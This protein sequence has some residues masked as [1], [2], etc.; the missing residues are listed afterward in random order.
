[1][2]SR[3]VNPYVKYDYERMAR[4]LGRLVRRFDFIT[5]SSIGET[6][7]GREIP[8]VRMGEGDKK[9]LLVGTHHGRE[10]ITAAY[11]MKSIELLCSLTAGS[12]ILQGMETDKILS[13][14]QLCFVPMLNPD[15]VNISIFGPGAAQYPERIEKMRLIGP[16]Y[17]T[18]KANANGV[19]LNRS[20]P[21]LFE[22]K[23]TLVQT[24]A[25]ELFKGAAPGSESE[26]SSLMRL[27]DSEGFIMAVSFHAKGEEIIWTDRNS[28][29]KI[30][31]AERIAQAA[32]DVS[33]YKI[34][35]PSSDPGGYAAGFENWFRERYL[36]PCLLIKISPDIGGFIPHNMKD[37][38][39]LVWDDAKY[40]IPVLAYTL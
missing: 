11:L 20:Y 39:R 4:D 27:C 29:G 8:M 40:I 5:S 21:C 22:Q 37:F 7:E 6:F 36:K 16:T 23:S 31:E 9:I 24:P 13:G 26:A 1:M 10:Y 17:E 28:A 30:P 12:Y 18:W 25:S 3:I 35:P 19:D 34:M 2:Q 38:D 15:G 32:A 33:G 14:K